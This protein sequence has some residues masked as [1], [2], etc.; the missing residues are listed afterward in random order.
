MLSRQGYVVIARNMFSRQGKCCQGK[1]NIF[2]GDDKM[3]SRQGKCCQ[4][5]KKCFHGKNKML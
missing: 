1:D 4:G 2:Q 3:L 5:K